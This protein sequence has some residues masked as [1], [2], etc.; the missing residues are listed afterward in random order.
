MYRAGLFVSILC[1]ALLGCAH[2]TP[3]V[4]VPFVGCKSDG[5]VGPLDA[6]DG[7]EQ[8]VRV[9]AEAASK[10]A[11]YKS[12]NLGVLAPRGWFC[13]GTYGSGGYGIFVAPTPIDWEHRP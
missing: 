6:P 4:M 12:E 7:V 11:Y 9:S 5:Q 2:E 8:G 13:F 10:L 1:S 3:V